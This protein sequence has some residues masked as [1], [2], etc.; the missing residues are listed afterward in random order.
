M[1]SCS[2]RNTSDYRTVRGMLT[3]PIGR[4]TPISQVDIAQ[5]TTE[6]TL[7]TISFDKDL[8]ISLVVYC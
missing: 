1:W 8:V 5:K 7:S 3:L 4:K 6:L 2:W